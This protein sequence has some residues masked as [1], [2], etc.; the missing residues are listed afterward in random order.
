[1]IALNRSVRD[2]AGLEAYWKA[3]PPTF[4]GRGARFLSVYAP[5]T[6]LE[7][8]SSLEGVVLIE[9]PDVAA[10]SSSGARRSRNGCEPSCWRSRWSCA[11]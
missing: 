8:M 3:A 7:L 1:M 9:F 5:L 4:E 6:P 2:R 10:T 11:G